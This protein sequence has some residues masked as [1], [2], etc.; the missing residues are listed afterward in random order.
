MPNSADTRDPTDSSEMFPRAEFFTL[1]G[2]A[3]ALGTSAGVGE[4]A[5]QILRSNEP[6]VAAVMDSKHTSDSYTV[7]LKLH[8]LDIDALYVERARVETPLQLRSVC[9]L[10][11]SGIQFGDT[12]PDRADLPVRIGAGQAADLE[13]VL[14][15][16]SSAD[17]H[18][19]ITFVVAR[20]GKKAIQEWKAVFLIRRS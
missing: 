19:T 6:F 5:W 4:K 10:K 17:T 18:G 13:L 9:H 12:K 16:P 3:A 15:A 11:Q 20:L 1:A 7:D 14:E 2:I 8:N